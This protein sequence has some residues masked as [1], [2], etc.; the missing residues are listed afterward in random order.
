LLS[1]NHIFSN[2]RYKTINKGIDKKKDYQASYYN[3]G[4]D[5]ADF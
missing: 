3:P 2:G 4:I 1:K 5:Y